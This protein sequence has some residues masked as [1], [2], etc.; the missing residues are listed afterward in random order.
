MGA[1]ATNYSDGIIAPASHHIQV[2]V[3]QKG[4]KTPWGFSGFS[5]NFH[6]SQNLVNLC[7]TDFVAN[8][9][10]KTCWFG[11]L[12]GGGGGANNRWWKTQ[13]SEDLQGERWG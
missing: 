13:T 9:A 11:W 7:N 3:A 4:W 12:A 1:T 5:S 8:K 2:C 10:E 6:P